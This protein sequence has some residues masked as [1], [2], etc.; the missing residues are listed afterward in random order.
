MRLGIM[1]IDKRYGMRWVCLNERI[2]EDF[3]QVKISSCQGCLMQ[4]VVKGHI[5]QVDLIIHRIQELTAGI[6]IGIP[7]LPTM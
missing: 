1:I 7:E 5:E 2:I 4:L 3:G 6:Q